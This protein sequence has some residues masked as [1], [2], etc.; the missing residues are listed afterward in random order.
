MEA[1][2]GGGGARLSMAPGSWGAARPHLCGKD[3]LTLS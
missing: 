2:G 3:E 1:L